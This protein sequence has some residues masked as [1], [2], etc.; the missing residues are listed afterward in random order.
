MTKQ[1]FSQKPTQKPTPPRKIKPD[2]VLWS[3]P[4]LTQY[5]RRKSVPVPGVNVI[6]RSA[7]QPCKVLFPDNGRWR[8]MF[9]THW[10]RLV[11]TCQDFDNCYVRRAFISMLIRSHGGS[12]SCVFFPILLWPASGVLFEGSWEVPLGGEAQVSAYGGGC[13]I[14]I[15]EEALCLLCFFFEDKVGQGLASLFFEF[16]RQMCT[17]HE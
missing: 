14:S 15:A 17:A 6:M 3:P 5:H 16:S 1:R 2:R 9:P 8:V 7:E 4:G 10:R 12:S 11:I 13:F